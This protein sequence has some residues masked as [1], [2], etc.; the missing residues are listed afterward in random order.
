MSNNK[1][2]VLMD[3]YCMLKEND[4]D[5]LGRRRTAVKES[6]KMIKDQLEPHGWDM[7]AVFENHMAEKKR[8]NSA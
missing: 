6:L 4:R 2:R 1:T 5:G 3:V 7:G 8:G